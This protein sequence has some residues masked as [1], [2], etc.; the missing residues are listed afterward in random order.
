[1]FGLCEV[2]HEFVMI[3]VLTTMCSAVA[4]SVAFRGLLLLLSTARVC[5]SALHTRGVFPGEKFEGVS[6]A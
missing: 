6:V 3:V 4:V 1:M 5:G 2:A